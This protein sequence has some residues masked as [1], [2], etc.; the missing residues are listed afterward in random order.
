MNSKDFLKGLKLGSSMQRGKQ[1][2]LSLSLMKD[3]S[4][5]YMFVARKVTSEE[6]M[7][8]QTFGET[9]PKNGNKHCRPTSRLLTI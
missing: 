8:F 7:E 2:Y 4:F 6:R 9:F 3:L 1:S 5:M